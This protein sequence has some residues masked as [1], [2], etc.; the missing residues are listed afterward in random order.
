MTY[1]DILTQ[2]RSE[3]PDVETIVCINVDASTE[4]L[5]DDLPCSVGVHPRSVE[6]D[7][8]DLLLLARD[9][10]HEP[11]V[12]AIGGCGLDR[13]I[14]ADWVQQ[15]HAFEDQVS[16]SELACK[17]MIVHCVRA[18]ADVVTL[19]RELQAEQPWIISGFDKGPDTLERIMD[20]GI[21]V[22][23]GAAVMKADSPAAQSAAVVAADRL[24]LETGYQTEYTIKQIYNQV[25]QLRGETVEQLCETIQQNFDAMF[26]Q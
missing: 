8:D 2:H 25:A 6:D 4:D 12:V 17:P 21:Y 16:L 5:A 1:H 18:H 24:F 3:E 10:S 19:Y 13:A 23:F 26:K 15:I 7:V 11:S 20:A 22:S 9:L 14:R